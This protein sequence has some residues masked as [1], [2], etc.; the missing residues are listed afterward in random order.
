MAGSS[1]EAD[2]GAETGFAD[3]V[4]YCRIGGTPH[5][6]NQADLQIIYGPVVNWGP[7]LEDP[8]L[9]LVILAD[10]DQ[11]S[12][13]DQSLVGIASPLIQGGSIVW[14]DPKTT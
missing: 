11:L 14:R 12:F 10:T 4:R 6:P 5:R 7:E 13:H 2:R 8:D 9:E 3:F 1:A